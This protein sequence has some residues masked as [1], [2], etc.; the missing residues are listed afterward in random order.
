MS[1]VCVRS[2]ICRVFSSSGSIFSFTRKGE[3]W[4]AVIPGNPSSS[5]FRE[6]GIWE[7]ESKSREVSDL[8]AYSKAPLVEFP[9]SQPVSPLSLNWNQ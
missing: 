8:Y 2:I 5:S 6:A 1:G 4:Q 7:K 3:P 9:Y